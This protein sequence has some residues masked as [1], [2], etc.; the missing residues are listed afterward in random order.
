V[1]NTKTGASTRN[2]NALFMEIIP[3]RSAQS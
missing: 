2:T 1:R 3:L